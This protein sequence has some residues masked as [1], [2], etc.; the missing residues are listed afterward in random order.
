[1]AMLNSASAR[2]AFTGRSLLADS[3]YNRR[4]AARREELAPEIIVV[5]MTAVAAY[6]DQPDRGG[7]HLLLEGD[8]SPYPLIKEV[9]TQQKTA[10]WATYGKVRL[11]ETRVGITLIRRGRF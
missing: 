9:K 8:V 6:L 3:K 7:T 2:R 11:M 5:L 10:F 1:M 4:Q